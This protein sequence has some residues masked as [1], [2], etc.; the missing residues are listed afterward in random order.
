MAARKKKASKGKKKAKWGGRREGA[1]RPFGSGKG[2][3][4]LSRRNRV[5]IML[6]DVELAA[7]K[8]MSGSVDGCGVVATEAH[9]SVILILQGYGYL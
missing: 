6:T 3:S 2:P 1:G 7:L 8:E 9:A 5:A 4:P